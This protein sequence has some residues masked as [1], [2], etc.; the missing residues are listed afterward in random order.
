MKHRNSETASRLGHFATLFF[1]AAVGLRAAD[2]PATLKDAFKDYFP[3]GTAVN[4]SMIAGGAGF[5]RSA[6]Q[7]AADVA[8]LKQH[9]N[10]IVAEN[11]MKWQLIHPR[12]GQDGYDFAP[13]DALVN[14]GRSNQMEVAGHTLVW[15][16]QLRLGSRHSLVLSYS[17][18]CSG[19]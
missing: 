7:H 10:Q 5:R 8:T 18:P 13:A 3:I 2:A 12:E 19:T 4:R 9:F 11:D 6:E 14:F 17:A 16:N 15:H 1:A